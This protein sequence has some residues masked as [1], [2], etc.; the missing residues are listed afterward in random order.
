MS[1][2]PVYWSQEIILHGHKALAGATG[3]SADLGE[4][5]VSSV[6]VPAVKAAV[7]AILASIEFGAASKVRTLALL[8][9]TEIAVPP[10]SDA[11]NDR[12]KKSR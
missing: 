11:V 7:V 12:P 8:P 5:I 6:R 10:E 9:V 1:W 3:P 4:R 2:S